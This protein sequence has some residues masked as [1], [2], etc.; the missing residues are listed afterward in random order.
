MML[1]G[2]TKGI[3]VK[4]LKWTVILLKLVDLIKGIRWIRHLR[5]VVGLIFMFF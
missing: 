2:F 1:V 5:D 4:I 3:G